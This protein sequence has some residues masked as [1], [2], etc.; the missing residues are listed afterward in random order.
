M[1]KD[2]IKQKYGEKI[3]GCR[4]CKKAD[5]ST[6]MCAI[7]AYEGEDG[8]AFEEDK[9]IKADTEWMCYTCAKSY[10]KECQDRFKNHLIQESKSGNQGLT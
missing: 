8:D 4:E 3:V 1:N 7:E 9:L 5:L 10:W 2:Y 6:N